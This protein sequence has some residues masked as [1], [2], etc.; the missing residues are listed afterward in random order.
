VQIL[1]PPVNIVT[2]GLFTLAVAAPTRC[3]VAAL[4][5]PAV[6]PFRAASWGAP[7]IAVV[8]TARRHLAGR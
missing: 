3:V 4:T 5:P 8:R 6:A 1:P 2:P 7:L